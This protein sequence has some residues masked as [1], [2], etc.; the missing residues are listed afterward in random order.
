MFELIKRIFNPKPR[1]NSP[2][3]KPATQPKPSVSVPVKQEQPR[4][5]PVTVVEPITVPR[6]RVQQV[7]P[8]PSFSIKP[9]EFGKWAG[10]V[11][12]RWE[13][14][15]DSTV[16]H[17]YYGKGTI[18]YADREAD[19]FGKIILHILME[20]DNHK[21]AF[22]AS[23]FEKPAAPFFDLQV[24]A[25]CHTAFQNGVAVLK[26]LEA[27]EAA[28]KVYAAKVNNWKNDWNEI[29]GVLKNHQIKYLYHFTDAANLSSI[30]K[31][32]GLYSW[33]FSQKN[34]IKIPRPGGNDTSRALDTRR[35]LQ[36]YVRLSFNDNHPM[37]KQALHEGRIKNPL[38]LKINSEV[39]FWK[40]TLFS[41]INAAAH[42]AQIGE[43]IEDLRRVRFEIVTQPYYNEETKSLYQS[44]VLVKTHIPLK[45]ILNLP[46]K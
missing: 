9:V 39:L 45:Y 34:N 22:H 31:H 30:I 24:N 18:I 14:L 43:S 16:H 20:R 6:P 5:K 44:E 37:L 7:V 46:E 3:P 2:P 28:E 17:T 10:K 26:E 40:S 38:V 25:R 11:L 21:V 1:R 23:D 8:K 32:G 36:D 27:M 12:A 42:E 41:D 15:V 29:A 33:W 4:P 35:K 19:R 13:L